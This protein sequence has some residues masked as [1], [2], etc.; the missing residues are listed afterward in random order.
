MV[1]AIAAP[2]FAI[3]SR[4]KRPR[5]SISPEIPHISTAAPA[6]CSH[7]SPPIEGQRL[8]QHSLPANPL[9]HE[10]GTGCPRP[11]GPFRVVEHLHDPPGGHRGAAIA[12]APPP[13]TL[14]DP[15]RV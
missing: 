6:D 12:H 9:P 8:F 15:S 5:L 7:S 4:E 13:N 10:G 14:A 2:R 1:G 11:L 3:S